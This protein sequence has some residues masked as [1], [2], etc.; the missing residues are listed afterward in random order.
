LKDKCHAVKTTLEHK[1]VKAKHPQANRIP[2]GAQVVE[3]PNGRISEI[4]RT[5]SKPAQNSQKPLSITKK[6]KLFMGIKAFQLD[7][8]IV[9][10][11][12]F[13][14]SLPRS[15]IARGLPESNLQGGKYTKIKSIQLV[16]KF[17]VMPVP[18]LTG[19]DIKAMDGTG[20]ST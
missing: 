9:I 13:R 20:C 11:P 3:R 4:L 1:L 15:R 6:S 18:Y 17:F 16:M 12:S 14:Q 7:G 2:S 19:M 8:T 5:P 10:K